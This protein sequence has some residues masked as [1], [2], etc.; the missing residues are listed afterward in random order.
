MAAHGFRFTRFSLFI[1]A[2]MLSVVCRASNIEDEISGFVMDRTITRQGHDYV[3]YLSDFR[4]MN[5]LGSYNLTVYERPSARWGNLIWVEHNGR[6][7][8]RTFLSASIA[9][10]STIAEKSA[11]QIHEEVRRQQLR[12]LLTDKHDLAG[13]EF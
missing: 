10:V 1:I 8:F 12:Q 9:D 11:L 13:D 3:R 6:E 7:V 5:D 2:A 4:N